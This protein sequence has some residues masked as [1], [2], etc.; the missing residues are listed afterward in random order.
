MKK[1]FIS[2]CYDILHAGHLQFFREAKAYGDHLTV[3]FASDNVLWEHKE[4]RS[5]IPQDHKAE[6]LRSLGMIDEVVIGEN[7]KLGLDFIDHFYQIKP[8]YLIVT[9]DDSYAE[10]KKE[11]CAEVGAKYI[12]LDKTPPKF[13]QVST[14]SIV[15]WIRAP[16]SAPLRIDFAG[17]WLDVPKYSRKGAYIVNCAISPCVS[18][19]D[20]KYELRS[21]LGGSG[22]WALLNGESGVMSELNLGVG[23]Q[24]PAIIKEGGL[25]IWKSG[26]IPNLYMKRN[27]DMLE[28]RM[29]LYYT[30]DQHD[31]PGTV[32]KF[33][34]LDLIE[35]AGRL[36]AKAVEDNDLDTLAQAIRLSYECQLG[37]GMDELPINQHSIAQ[38][39]GGGGW[40]GYA[41]YLFSNKRHRDEFV[42]ENTDALEIEP[43]NYTH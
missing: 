23:W 1:V 40:G 31:T 19:K 16:S 30:G 37:E 32:D 3:S 4:R 14:S 5:S 26:N 15:K 8:D 11:L 17:G 25:C 20:W 24:D 10:S 21:G 43:F 42:K 34:D 6:L 36:A 2:G 28:G 35:K 41:L 9:Q 33:R 27:G 12:V 22:A 7:N 13:E 18:L 38:K 29:A 39:Y